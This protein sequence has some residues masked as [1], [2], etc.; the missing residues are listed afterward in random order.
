[1]KANAHANKLIFNN[2]YLAIID[3][4]KYHDCW[5]EFSKNKKIEINVSEAK[6]NPVS[7]NKDF[8]FY[9]LVF[10]SIKIDVPENIKQKFKSFCIK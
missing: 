3:N 6:L 4:D 5:L 7:A 2:A 10:S 8:I 1:M 9:E